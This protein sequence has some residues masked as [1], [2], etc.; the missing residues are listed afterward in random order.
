MTRSD[1]LRSFLNL[2]SGEGRTASLMIAHAFAMGA[3]TVFFET[4]ASALFL[5]RFGAGSL[6]YVY[7]AAAAVNTVTGAAY[8]AVQPRLRFRSLM[9]GTVGVLLV[10]VAGVRAG[11]ALTDA[12]WLTFFLLVWYRVLS[13]LTDLEYWAVAARLYDLRQAK[14]LFGLIGSGE[15]VARIAG[16]FF[17][18]LALRFVGVKDLFV[19]S[20]V[21]LAA[22]LL[23]LLAVLPG[24]AEETPA[25][26]GRGRGL[27][28]ETGALARI[29]GLLRDPYVRLVLALAFLG[30][31]GKYFVDFAFL[32]QMRSRYAD[33]KSLASFF[34]VFSG[35]SQV[36]SLLTRVLLSSRVLERYG[37]RVGLLVL[38]GFHVACTTLVVAAGLADSAGMAVFWL[39][40]ANQGIYKTLKHPIDN[41]SFKVLYQPLKKEIRLSA[42]IAVETLVTPVTI[43]IAG[44]LMLASN[45]LA[46]ANPVPFA[47]LMLAG[48]GAWAVVAVRAG[49]A[50]VPALVKALAGR[51]ADHTAF[52]ANDAASLAVLR[53]TLVSQRPADVLFALD[54]VERAEPES[55]DRTLADLL[56]HPQ[57]EVRRSVLLR[58]ERQR[59]RSLARAVAAHLAS[60]TVPSALAAAHRCLASIDPSSAG[61]V[62][63]GL[64][65]ADAE[66]RRGALVGLLEAGDPEAR[67]VLASTA[68]SAL[69]RDRAEAAR[70][71]GE[72]GVA[73]LAPVLES[74]LAD[75]SFA[76]RRAALTAAGRLREPSLWTAVARDLDDD[77]LC[78]SAA[79]VL[80]SVGPK[81]VAELQAGFGRA[82]HRRNRVRIARALGRSRDPG[83]SRFL[84]DQ[85]GYPDTRVRQ[86]ILSALW[87]LGFTATEGQ[88]AAIE[89][90]IRREAADAAAAL[91]SVRDLSDDADLS[92]LRDAFLVEVDQ[93]RERALLLLGLVHDR[94]TVDRARD[95]LRHPTRERRAYAVEILDVLLSGSVRDAVL[96]LVEDLPPAERLERLEA[97]FPQTRLAVEEVVSQTLRGP[98]EWTRRWTKAAALRAVGNLKLH[99]LHADVA[100]LAASTP[101]PLLAET[102]AWALAA[103]GGVVSWRAEKTML[104]IEKIIHLKAVQMFSRASEEILADIAAV[105]EEVEVGPGDVVFRKGD[106]GDSL[107]IVVEGRVRVFDA[108][109]T[110]THLGE[111][112]IFGELALLDPEPRFASVEAVKPT[113]L[114]RLDREAFTELMED[115][116]EIVRGVLSVLCDRLRHTTPTAPRPA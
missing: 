43:G 69:D 98:D 97:L 80:A 82:A 7:L 47:V 84:F 32:G 2:E 107:Y 18:P 99:A 33:T 24:G 15:V 11:L 45:A 112:E 48:F 91:G 68:A 51:F 17:V 72:A 41:P 49:R 50:Y 19:L 36:L 102:S 35:T 100:A 54:L 66:V 3:S 26:S 22:C 109:R 114:L 61:R 39:V 95:N 77:R 67:I 104:T 75:S 29:G 8:T 37:V 64:G 76:V 57:P 31:L 46:G 111:L 71:I 86:E 115:N 81:G 73:A 70:V 30:V 10:S 60:E 101:S 110:I 14:R 85:I 62:R 116:I 59:R 56:A 74:L 94:A 78:R 28:G 65:H 34:A 38:P 27:A 79:P 5:A 4:A 58:I 106:V 93:A 53:Q 13:I 55:L 63:E 113:R 103:L 12:A 96:P 20:G 44:V 92:L 88:A 83:A 52:S 9:V 1:R 21:A 6:P 105:L 89:E 16:S 25:A 108:D 87:V 40:V 90:R 42:Q 23:L